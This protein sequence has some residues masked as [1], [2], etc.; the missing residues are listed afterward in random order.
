VLTDSRAD[1][2]L[3]TRSARLSWRRDEDFGW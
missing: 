1:M 3:V 2:P